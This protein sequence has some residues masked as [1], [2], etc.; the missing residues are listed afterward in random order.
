MLAGSSSRL[1]GNQRMPTAQEMA[2]MDEMIDKLVDAKPYDL[3]S[4]VKRAFQVIRSP[5]FFLRIAERA[6]QAKDDEARQRF[7]V[8]ASNLVTTLEAVVETTAEQLDERARSVESV[9][10]TAAEPDSGEFLVPLA[11]ERITAMRQA[12]SNLSEAD[13][14]EGFLVTLDAWIVKSH[15]DGMDGMV[16][17]LQKVL[18]MFAGLSVQ[19]AIESQQSESSSEG[20]AGK[21]ELFQLLDADESDWDSMLS[22][23]PKETVA[24]VRK[25]LQRTMETVILSLETGSMNQQVQAEYCKELLQR[26]ETAEK[27]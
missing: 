2:L 26:V 10:K 17:I 11:T 13:L 20:T 4:A 9:V 18:Q 27:S 16:G 3:P 5:Q 25:L 24:D 6:D 1:E 22:S 8:L 23:Q 14:D 21:A 19:R 7:E 15:Q 12:L